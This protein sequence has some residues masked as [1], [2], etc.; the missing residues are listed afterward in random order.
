[1]CQW[2]CNKV[3]ILQKSPKKTAENIKII[4]FNEI[5]NI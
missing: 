4:F 1:M 3:V 5:F 2:A